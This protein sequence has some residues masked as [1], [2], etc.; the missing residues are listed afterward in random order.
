MKENILFGIELE[1]G[2]NESLGIQRG[3]Y[4]SGV[5]LNPDWAAESDSSLGFRSKMPIE[6]VSRVFSAKD[7]PNVIKSLKETLGEEKDKFENISINNSCGCHIHFSTQKGVKVN[8]FYRQIPYHTLKRIRIETWRQIKSECPSIFEKFKKQYFR[9]YSQKMKFE[10]KSWSKQGREI[11]FHS[12]NNKGMEWRS[13]N[14][15]GVKTWSELLMVLSIGINT[16]EKVLNEDFV[17]VKTKA[18]KYSANKVEAIEPEIPEED[19]IEVI[20]HELDLL[21]IDQNLGNTH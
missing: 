8:H 19:E 16:I 20:N 2:V 10:E 14:L 21:S 5:Y 12:T 7:L 1:C 3:G 18:F 6:F 11:E 9:N 15:S 4:H 17:Q 13:F